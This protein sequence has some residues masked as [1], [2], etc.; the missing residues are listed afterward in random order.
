MDK[1]T[2]EL[3]NELMQQS[4]LDEYLSQNG[5]CLRDGDFTDMLEGFF[6][7]SGLTKAALAR[8]AGIS[9][10]Y[11]HQ[12][13]SGRR[14]PSR[15][16]LICICIGMRLGIRETQLLLREASCAALYPRRR[17]DAIICHGIAHKKGLERINNKLFDENEKTL[18]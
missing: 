13:F 6:R 7:E 16:K 11:L 12:V 1:P 8:G 14:N 3:L 4:D 17:R 18:F 2:G 5:G 15:D 10:V 9:E